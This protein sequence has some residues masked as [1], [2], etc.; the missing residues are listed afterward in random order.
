MTNKLKTL[1]EQ[2]KAIVNAINAG[3]LHEDY[4]SDALEKLTDAYAEEYGVKVDWIPEDDDTMC[5]IDAFEHISEMMLE[6]T[7]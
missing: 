6:E 1:W 4:Q 2:H 3:A 5:R 7:A